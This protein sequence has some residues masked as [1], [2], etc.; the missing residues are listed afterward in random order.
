M[1]NVFIDNLYDFMDKEL[2]FFLY[3]AQSVKVAACH[4]I[5]RLLRYKYVHYII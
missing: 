2:C 5:E 3:V 4:L 1:V